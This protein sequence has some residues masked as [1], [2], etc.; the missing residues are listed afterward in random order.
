MNN[1]NSDPVTITRFHF[2][3]VIIPTHPGVIDSAEV[4]KPLHM[5]PVGGKKD[6]SAQFDELP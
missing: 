1:L 5:L 4:S 2:D 6:W 3:E